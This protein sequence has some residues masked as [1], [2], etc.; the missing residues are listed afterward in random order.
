MWN[1]CVA[2]FSLTNR[3]SKL[4]IVMKMWV[5]DGGGRQLMIEEVLIFAFGL[6]IPLLGSAWSRHSKTIFVLEGR[7]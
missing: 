3:Y 5:M 6:N 4:E 7:R 1:E 2:V